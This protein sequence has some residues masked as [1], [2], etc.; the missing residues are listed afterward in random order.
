MVLIFTLTI[1]IEILWKILELIPALPSSH[2]ANLINQVQTI[3]DNYFTYHKKIESQIM[4]V[5]TV[6][7][8]VSDRAKK[9]G[10]NHIRVVYLCTYITPQVH[11]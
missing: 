1:E 9:M 2:R 7:I 6:C 11:M 5:G 8:P 10:K 3:C 4:S